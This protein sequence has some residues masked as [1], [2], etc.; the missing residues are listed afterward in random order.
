MDWRAASVSYREEHGPF[1]TRSALRKVPRLGPKAFELSAGFLR[2][3]DA[4]DPLDTSGVHPEA[5]S[6][7]RRIL[8][9]TKSQL[10][11]LIGNTPVLRQLKPEAFTDA[12][13]GVPTVTD[14]LRELEKPGRDPRPVFKTAR[15]REGVEKLE[16]LKPGMVLEGVVTNVAAFG[17]FVDVG[18]PPGRAGAHFRNGQ[19]LRLRSAQDRDTRRDRPSQSVGGRPETPSDLVNDAAR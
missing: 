1:H 11:A 17:A 3:R 9:A 15:F 16:D 12:V 18:G 4:D 10:G 2:I 6:V 13:F 5:Y 14:I 7:V 8:A 19:Y